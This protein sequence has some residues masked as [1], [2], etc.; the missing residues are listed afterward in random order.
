[1]GTIPTKLSLALT[2]L[3]DY[4]L[5]HVFTD[6]NDLYCF[7]GYN[8]LEDFLED[9]ENTLHLMVLKLFLLH[10]NFDEEEN[11]EQ[12]I[13]LIK[14]HLINSD[15]PFFGLDDSVDFCHTCGQ[16]VTRVDAQ[17]VCSGCHVACYCSLD[18][19]RMT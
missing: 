17:L 4:R 14:S 9:K 19:Q 3:E 7:Q 10:K 1:M 5:K 8:F 2:Y 12:A 13:A 18:H 6:S 15:L 16:A 11:I